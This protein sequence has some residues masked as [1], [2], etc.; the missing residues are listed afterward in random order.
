MILARCKR[1]RLREITKLAIRHPESAP[2]YLLAYL[3][4]QGRHPLGLVR[5][6]SGVRGHRHDYAA[7]PRQGNQRLAA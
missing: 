1:G 5:L 2:S 6:A 7:A 3:R 4:S